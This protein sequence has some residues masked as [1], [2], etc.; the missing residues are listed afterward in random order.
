[1]EEEKKEK[2][3]TNTTIGLM[4]TVALFLDVL[5]VLLNFLLMGWLVPIF[6]YG[7]FWLWFRMRG[8]SFFSLKRAPTLGIGAVIELIPWVDDLPMFTFT[9]VRIAL[10]YKI[11]KVAGV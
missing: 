11:K 6:F 3:L 4:V 7:I 1:M 8:L 10:D 5:Q 9:V 2:G